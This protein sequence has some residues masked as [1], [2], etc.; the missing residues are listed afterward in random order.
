MNPI[1][2]MH[3]RR[4]ELIQLGR[5]GEETMHGPKYDGRGMYKHGLN[6]RWAIISPK[7]EPVEH[8]TEGM[9]DL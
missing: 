6:F 5:K 3:S 4:K 1:Y 7:D 9:K 8:D 2:W